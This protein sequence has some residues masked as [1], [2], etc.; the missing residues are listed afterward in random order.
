MVV[1]QRVKKIAGVALIYETRVT[2][3]HLYIAS[4]STAAEWVTYGRALEF[5]I[6]FDTHRDALALWNE[7][8][9]K[10]IEG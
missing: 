4:D 8:R 9:I 7:K 6:A 10:T 2:G 3:G 5:P 1:F